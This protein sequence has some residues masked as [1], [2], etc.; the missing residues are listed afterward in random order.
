MDATAGRYRNP[1]IV[2]VWKVDR[3]TE[4]RIGLFHRPQHFCATWAIRWVTNATAGQLG[5]SLMAGGRA[6]DLPAD[7]T[8]WHLFKQGTE[9]ATLDSV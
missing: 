1:E 8:R 7:F 6:V 4:V 5:G 9:L 2:D 3:E